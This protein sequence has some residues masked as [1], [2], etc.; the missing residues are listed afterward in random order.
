[1]PKRS[2]L[3]P[4][5]TIC[6]KVDDREETRT[7]TILKKIG[8]GGCA[9]CYQARDERGTI[10][11]LKEFYPKE[12]D[13]TRN[14]V[15]QL[16]CGAPKDSP[17]AKR[18]LDRRQEYLEPYEHLRV[19]RCEPE[20]ANELSFLP[21]E[22]IFRSC[23]KEGQ[24]G[25][26]YIWTEGPERKIFADLCDDNRLHPNQ[27]PEYKLALTLYAIRALAERVRNLNGAGY[28]HRDIKP[29]NFGFSIVGEE[30]QYQDLSIFDIDTMVPSGTANQN[31]GSA[32]T[33]GYQEPEANTAGHR[34]DTQTDIYSIGATLFHA[35]VIRDKEE[36]KVKGTVYDDGDWE[37]LEELVKNSRLIRASECNSNPRL[38]RYLTTILKKCLAP[39][40]SKRGDE[41]EERYQA[42]E[43]LLHDLEKALSCVFSPELL[44]A[45]KGRGPR[46]QTALLQAQAKAEKKKQ[47]DSL[48]AFQHH[49]YQVPLYRCLSM[50]E[51]TKKDATLR[52]L[53]VGFGGYGQKFL[54]ACLQVAQVPGIKL[55]VTV[56][57]DE[58]EEDK[59]TYLKERPAL[60]QFF[61]VDGKMDGGWKKADG[62]AAKD[63]NEADIYGSITFKDGKLG[64]ARESRSVLE[65][66]VGH[67][68]ENSAPHY[69]FIALGEDHMNHKTAKNIA[70]LVKEPCVVSYVW[71]EEQPPKAEQGLYPICVSG[72]LKKDSEIERMAFNVHRLWNKDRN[73]DYETLRREFREPY[74]H[75]S[76]VSNVISIKYKLHSLG[77]E[78][79]DPHEAARLFWEKLTGQEG[80]GIPKNKLMCAEHRR[81]VTEKLCQGWQKKELDP[82]CLEADRT[83]DK[84]EKRHI[85]IVHSRDNHPLKA[86]EAYWR[87]EDVDKLDE[88]DRVSVTMHRMF[89]KKAEETQIELENLLGEKSVEEFREALT[90]ESPKA[91][92]AFMEWRACMKDIQKGEEKKTRLYTGLKNAFLNAIER[93]DWLEAG[94]KYWREK[95]EAIHKSFYP[96][97]MAARRRDWKQNDVDMV[98]RIPFIL[99]YTTRATLVIR[100]KT[101]NVL[102]VF[103]N[104]AAVTVVDPS[105]ILYVYD[106]ER[107]VRNGDV[108]EA[109]QESLPGV[110][111]YLCHKN[112]RA[113]VK[114]I[115]VYKEKHK[116]QAEK[117]KKWVDENKSA[118]WNIACE[119]LLLERSDQLPERMEAL[120]QMCPKPH[121]LE[122][123]DITVGD[124][125]QSRFPWYSFDPLT[126]EFSEESTYKPVRYLRP[127]GCYIT[128]DDMFAFRRGSCVGR[129]LPDFDMDYT[130]LWDIYKKHTRAWKRLCVLL[131]QY[132]RPDGVL[133]KASKEATYQF[134]LP[135]VCAEGAKKIVEFLKKEGAIHPEK[136]KVLMRSAGR[137]EVQIT[138][139][140]NGAQGGVGSQNVYAKIFDHCW[141]GCPDDI[142]CHT[143][144]VNNKT[145]EVTVTLRAREV[146]ELNL[147]ADASTDANADEVCKLLKELAG[148]KY[149]LSLYDKDI[150][151]VSFT[152]PSLV[153]R[154][155]LIKAGD[156]LETYVYHKAK[157]VGAFDDVVS[158]YKVQWGTGEESQNELDCVIT[159]GFRSL[160]IE[161]KATNNL[162]QGYYE[163]MANLV[164]QLSVNGTG[165]IITDSEVAGERIVA[166]RGKN[167]KLV[168]ISGVDDLERLDQI[169][170]EIME[171]TYQE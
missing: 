15:G 46:M 48:W 125:L 18:F 49:L 43:D 69:I 20:E 90:K 139:F 19:L 143:A 86:N 156:M 37:N 51:G 151:N 110:M 7:F 80:Q 8:D 33:P 60:N 107:V 82:S 140:Y 122:V 75:D 76:C 22:E 57:A 45:M 148:R 132:K 129:N 41:R 59:A 166:Q 97:L 152:F 119:S 104:V 21:T 65:D 164:N 42:V 115:L 150:R 50:E 91:W 70:K 30:V 53:L 170:L 131:Q 58:L 146:R 55:N 47:K 26:V 12:Y 67:S 44:S 96:V 27:K 141:L 78:L 3:G 149:I 16:I 14:R 84:N 71:E 73:V 85:C 1:M 133:R 99:T 136:S 93:D 103:R 169:L 135:A 114:L 40:K 108:E 105:R 159:K 4:Q 161:C 102:D 81:W 11:I 157:A 113:A 165:V 38:R 95:V 74:N 62:T 54:D 6:L 56:M 120:M 29:T 128:V 5:R 155:L 94:A 17:L 147:N 9:V 87:G 2:C 98:E 162:Q 117:L 168:T 25:T 23:V 124:Q 83:R 116:A 79:D 109:L 144:K 142:V 100:Y 145:E 61:K 13:L 34:F 64:S 138:A 52:V 28:I 32:G 92:T 36:E 77:I 160:L 66:V 72:D 137:C 126:M 63:E 171:G 24:E 31:G 88:L 35:I 154:D 111:D 158:G 101:G 167:M 153:I 121:I 68:G 39:R 130:A 10:G 106:L 163:R 118:A 89:V 112:L 134:W 127:D 123:D